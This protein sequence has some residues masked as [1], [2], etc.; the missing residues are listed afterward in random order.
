MENKEF[1]SLVEI[2][3]EAGLIPEWLERDR[4]QGR[5]NVARNAISKG[6][7]I[8]VIHDITGLDV[9]TIQQ[10]QATHG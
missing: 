3:E 4:I 5:E 7:P 10:L 1:S 2:F 6:L 9:E 8:D